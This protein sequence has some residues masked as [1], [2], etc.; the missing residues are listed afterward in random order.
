MNRFLLAAV[1]ALSAATATAQ[2][3]DDTRTMPACPHCGMDREK[4]AVSRMVVDY[5]DGK[6]VGLCS[7]HCVAVELAVA[8]D[9]TPTAIW[10]ADMPS[11]KLVNAE[12]AVWVLG[13]TKSGVMTSRA[14][15]AFA[16]KA[17]AEAF[18]KEN[19][20]TIAG[21]EDAMK[22]AYEDLYKDS[23]AIREK[24]KMMKSKAAQKP[25]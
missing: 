15:W 12:T 17:A 9:K 22:A 1:L 5:D 7:L 16:D 23:K 6:S 18:V 10:V 19:G 20:G 11:K 8:I 25:N 13:G 21:F 24:R 2:P 14:K 4:F 3:V